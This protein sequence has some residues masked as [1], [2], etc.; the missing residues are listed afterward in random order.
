MATADEYATWIVKNADKK[1]T[2]EFDTVAAAYKDARQSASGG[3]PVGR[4][5]STQEGTMGAYGTRRP[6]PKLPSMFTTAPQPE[7]EAA[8]SMAALRGFLSPIFPENTR[9][10][11]AQLGSAEPT[12]EPLKAAQFGGEFA[13]QTAITAPIGGLMARPL[14][15]AAQYAPAIAPYV[16][17]SL[18][19][20]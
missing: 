18:I 12:T 3:I 4:T 8:G 9:K 6:P 7:A 20:I 16:N 2:P 17:L 14:A 15:A 5:A 11:Y 10:L 13:G 19:H 1:G